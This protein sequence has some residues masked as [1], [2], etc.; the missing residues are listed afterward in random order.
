MTQ[1]RVVF[2]NYVDDAELKRLL[3]IA[4][5]YCNPARPAFAFLGGLEGSDG[6]AKR[7]ELLERFNVDVI[8]YN[9]MAVLMIASKG[10]Y[11]FTVPSS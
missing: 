3:K 4:A 1:K 11:G 7:I 8:P 5:F 6:E 9:M 10:A 2:S